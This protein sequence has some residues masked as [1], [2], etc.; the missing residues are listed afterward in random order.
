MGGRGI[1]EE[2]R[3]LKWSWEKRR[4][5]RG[6]KEGWR[7]ER[8]KKG[9]KVYRDVKLRGKSLQQLTMLTRGR[10]GKMEQEIQSG[11]CR[12]CDKGKDGRE[13]C[14]YMCFMIN[15]KYQVYVCV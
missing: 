3:D 4:R 2:W 13:V 5:R 7:Y 8:K 1:I 6:R 9:G 12:T 10:E 15:L 14:F 11:G